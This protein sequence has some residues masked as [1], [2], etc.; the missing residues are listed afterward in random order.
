MFQ[1][2]YLYPISPHS[3]VVH[4]KDSLF[5]H[6]LKKEPH[7]QALPGFHVPN[8]P[9]SMAPIPPAVPAGEEYGAREFPQFTDFH[10][11]KGPGLQELAHL[12]QD[13]PWNPPPSPA[14]YPTSYPEPVPPAY[15]PPRPIG[16]EYHSQTHSY[17][18]VT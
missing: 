12:Q 15:P 16:H 3:A 14:D 8:P 18:S 2:V 5:Y 6:E 4:T 10:V 1:T 9:S 17:V 13:K 11:D 7:P